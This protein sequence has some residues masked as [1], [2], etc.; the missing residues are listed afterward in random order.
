MQVIADNSLQLFYN[1][2][3]A[4]TNFL[5][6]LCDLGLT[7]LASLLVIFLT[8]GNC[9]SFQQDC[10][11][12][13]SDSFGIQISKLRISNFSSE[14]DIVCNSFRNFVNTLFRLASQ[15]YVKWDGKTYLKLLVSLSYTSMQ[16]LLC[17][18]IYKLKS[19]NPKTE[20]LLAIDISYTNLTLP[21]VS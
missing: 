21:D 1:R 9:F 11:L 15:T 18:F 16:I 4:V 2:I 3:I 6:N 20:L 7:C 10:D 13:R 19:R 17:S 5:F 12:P 14:S 8:V